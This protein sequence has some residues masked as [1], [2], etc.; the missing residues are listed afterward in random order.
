MQACRQ[1]LRIWRQMKPASQF[2]KLF[3]PHLQR[4]LLWKTVFLLCG[5]RVWLV[6][7]R[8]LSF[9]D[10]FL[11]QPSP[12]AIRLPLQPVFQHP[13]RYPFQSYSNNYYLFPVSH[14]RPDTTVRWNPYPFPAIPA[15]AATVPEKPAPDRSEIVKSWLKAQAVPEP[16]DGR[17]LQSSLF[18]PAGEW[19]VH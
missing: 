7:F 14:I 16:H 15:K 6:R 17:S 5:I 3:R 8:P 1:P 11:F 13:Y 19:P 9:S 4:P 10:A 18:L 12:L 2:Q